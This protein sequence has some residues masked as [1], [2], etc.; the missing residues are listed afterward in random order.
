MLRAAKR[1]ERRLV[2]MSLRVAQCAPLAN[3]ALLAQFDRNAL[4][5]L[6]TPEDERL[7]R[8]AKALRGDRIGVARN[9]H[10]EAIPE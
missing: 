3:L 4:V 5:R 9:G 10:G 2:G 1:R 6:E 7:E 8:M